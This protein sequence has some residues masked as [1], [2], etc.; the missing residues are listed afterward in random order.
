MQLSSSLTHTQ[1]T[2]VHVHSKGR[3]ETKAQVM[4]EG[5]GIAIAAEIPTHQ[6][7]VHSGIGQNRLWAWV[8][9]MYVHRTAL[10]L[11]VQEPER[12]SVAHWSDWLRV[13]V[14]IHCSFVPL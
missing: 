2:L 13:M 9:V 6:K 12:D 14:L 1:P 4:A 3:D 11:W 7:A 8:K 5:P 10:I